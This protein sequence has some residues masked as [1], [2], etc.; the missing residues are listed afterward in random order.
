MSRISEDF[1]DELAQES[2]DTVLAI[3]V[4]HQFKHFNDSQL[5]L[6]SKVYYKLVAYFP[7]YLAALIWASPEDKIRLV[8]LD[9]LVDECGGIE[10]IR[11][12]DLTEIHPNIFK[13]FAKSLGLSA[14]TLDDHT[15]IR[16]YSKK[17]LSDIT[18]LSTKSPFLVALGGVSPTLENTAQVWLDIIYK[19]LK[20]QKRFRDEDLFYFSM[21]AEVDIEH[22]RKFKDAILPLLKTEEDRKQLR[23][24]AMRMVAILDNLFNS[25]AID[26]EKLA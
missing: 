8:I 11:A 24:G 5:R 3:P 17:M 25:L 20:T 13:R 6:F 22:G 21:H 2:L 14:E 9:N 12:A 18:N 7:N 4:L 23:Q 10:K 16:T 1:F 26:L 19:D 15:D